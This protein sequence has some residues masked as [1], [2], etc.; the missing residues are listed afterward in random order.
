MQQSDCPYVSRH[1]RNGIFHQ[2]T[3]PDQKDGALLRNR[4]VALRECWMQA[5]PL[6][7]F[8]YAPPS[9][10]PDALF[11]QTVRCEVFGPAALQTLR[12]PA[13]WHSVRAWGSERPSVDRCRC[14]VSTP[15]RFF[16]CVRP[17]SHPSR[18]RQWVWMAGSLHSG[19]EMAFRSYSLCRR[20][21]ISGARERLQACRQ[22]THQTRRNVFK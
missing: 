10:W 11:G 12:Y 3:L 8:G 7:C 5:R 1:P 20:R 21:T 22:S 14:V 18:L 9:C 13:H 2:R 19:D 4:F 15:H 16:R 6:F 17:F